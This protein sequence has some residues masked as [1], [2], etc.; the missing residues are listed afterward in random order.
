VFYLVLLAFFIRL[1]FS[2]FG[3]I[4]ES[5]L[6][7]GVDQQRVGGPVKSPRP[8]TAANELVNLLM[9]AAVLF[10]AAG[11]V[12]ILAFWLYLAVVAGRRVGETL[13]PEAPTLAPL[14]SKPIHLLLVLGVMIAPLV[15]AGLD[16]G[17]F[18]W[19]D[20][21]PVSL[22]LVALFFVAA[23]MGFFTW[24]AHV[25]PFPESGVRIQN[26]RS[27]YVITSGPYALVRHPIF[28]AG[29]VI[30]PANGVALGSWLAAAWGALFVPLLV[31]AVAKKDRRLITE[32]P[33]YDAYARNIQYRLFPRVW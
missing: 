12:N 24:A 32:L 29:L 8:M 18:H 22:Q 27:H 20:A 6:R 23:S 26:D 10:V 5:S 4:I 14:P 30:L 25:H 9:I 21:V 13:F 2:F 19:S 28:L 31:W 3:A 1:V 33:G 11:R 15:I 7:A 16:R 17:R